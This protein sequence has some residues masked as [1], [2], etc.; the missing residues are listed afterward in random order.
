[1]RIVFFNIAWMKEY[2]GNVDGTDTP[3]FGGDYVQ[4]TGDGHEKYNFTPVSFQ[5]KEEYYCLGFYETKSY[6]GNT[7][8]QM[9]I[10]NINGCKLCNKEDYVEDV[11]VVYCAKHP[12]HKYTT[13]VGWYKH[14]TVFRNY[15]EAWFSEDEVQYYNAVAKASDC[16][17]L[18]VSVRSK[19]LQWQVPRKANG[20]KFGFGRAN[21]WYASELDDNLDVY[22]DRLVRQIDEY[23]GENW[24]NYPEK[25]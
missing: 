6:N 25:R 22:I 18:P 15:K 9:H 23:D 16:V 12:A 24:I 10:E 2:T 20:W 7:V 11:L 19:K 17:L 3:K 1:M 14:A 4:K 8:N 21:V 5:N 13:V